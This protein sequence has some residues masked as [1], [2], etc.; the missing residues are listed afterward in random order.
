MPVSQ[1]CLHSG[2]GTAAKLC[3]LPATDHGAVS[4]AGAQLCPVSARGS[5]PYFR[6]G[7]P[8]V[9]HLQPQPIH[10]YTWT[11]TYLLIAALQTHLV[12]AYSRTSL[13]S[14]R[15]SLSLVSAPSPVSSSSQCL[16][17]ELVLSL[18]VS[19]VSVCTMSMVSIHA[20]FDLT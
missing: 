12:L 15:H 17:L 5:L 18:C 4:C 16:L 6:S 19:T 9:C 8:A 20:C 10:M 1:L 14:Q 2:A 13:Q 3:H 7:L 11:A